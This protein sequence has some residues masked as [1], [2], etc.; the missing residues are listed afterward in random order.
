MRLSYVG[1]CCKKMGELM[2]VRMNMGEEG[3]GQGLDCFSIFNFGQSK[4]LKHEKCVFTKS[5]PGGSGTQIN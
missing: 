2:R 4:N 5:E 3:T 1:A